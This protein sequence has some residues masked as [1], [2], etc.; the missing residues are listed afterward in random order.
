M[1]DARDLTLSLLFLLSAGRRP[2]DPIGRL[3]AKVTRRLA[4]RGGN[5]Q[6]PFVVYA[7]HYEVGQVS[8]Y[9]VWRKRVLGCHD[10]EEL[11]VLI[12]MLASSMDSTTIHRAA[13]LARNIKKLL[14][15]RNCRIV[16]CHIDAKDGE[17]YFL[18]ADKSS[19]A[20]WVSFR[21]V[22]LELLIQ[23]RYG[24]RQKAIEKSQQRTKANSLNH[25]Y[26]SPSSEVSKLR[27]P[28]FKKFAPPQSTKR[29]EGSTTSTQVETM[30]QKNLIKN[31]KKL[32]ASGRSSHG[33]V[34]PKPKPT[35]SS[36]PAIPPSSLLKP[37]PTSSSTPGKLPSAMSLGS[38]QT[39]K[40]PKQVGSVNSAK[41]K[42]AGTAK[43]EGR[44]TNEGDPIHQYNDILREHHVAYQELLA[45]GSHTGEKLSHIR[46]GSYR[47][48][49]RL[50]SQLGS[51]MDKKR[52][53]NIIISCE[54]SDA[55]VPRRRSGDVESDGKGVVSRSPSKSS[56]SAGFSSIEAKRQQLTTSL[57][58]PYPHD[59]SKQS[60][61]DVKASA[62]KDS[63]QPQAHD[64]NASS[65][66][67]RGSKQLNTSDQSRTA[68]NSLPLSSRQVSTSMRST[69]KQPRQPPTLAPLLKSTDARK[70]SNAPSRS[71]SKSSSKKV[72]STRAK[73][74][75]GSTALCRSEFS[76]SGEAKETDPYGASGLESL[77]PQG[78]HHTGNSSYSTARVEDSVPRRRT[79]HP[80]STSSVPSL[81]SKRRRVDLPN[82]SPDLASPQPLSSFPDTRTQS[83]APLPDL[84]QEPLNVKI[85]NAGQQEPM[86]VE[87]HPPPVG[88]QYPNLRDNAVNLSFM[89]GDRRS[90]DNNQVLA[91]IQPEQAGV[92]EQDI[93][94]KNLVENA[95]RQH[96]TKDASVTDY[97]RY[98]TMGL[99]SS[100][101]SSSLYD[102]NKTNTWDMGLAEP[103]FPSESSNL[104][105]QGLTYP[106]LNPQQQRN[107]TDG[108]LAGLSGTTARSWNEKEQASHFLAHQPATSSSHYTSN[109]ELGHDPRYE[110]D[111]GVQQHGFSDGTRSING[112]IQ[113]TIDTVK[114]RIATLN[115]LVQQKQIGVRSDFGDFSSYQSFPIASAMQQSQYSQPNYQQALTTV[116]PSGNEG[117]RA[118]EQLL[119]PNPYQSIAMQQS[120][121]PSEA[122]LRWSGE[123]LLQAN[124]QSMLGSTAQHNDTRHV[125]QTALRT[126]AQQATAP[127]LLFGQGGSTNPS[128]S[129]FNP[130]LTMYHQD[131]DHYSSHFK[132][133]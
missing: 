94:M 126:N 15:P 2:F 24:Q 49:E 115:A 83:T 20:K 42:H 36:P 74:S 61:V 78:T 54:E 114:Q 29:D 89:S 67:S 50:M 132:S 86:M 81:S 14:L 82:Q 59:G 104:A 123:D 79:E 25:T 90:S 26:L 91:T 108:H 97:T 8:Y 43:S 41:P 5:I 1:L 70:K 66:A 16:S 75:S 77:K 120:V 118:F 39:P 3:P 22:D 87:Q 46:A 18:V 51:S 4:R 35:T 121:N 107:V 100:P 129:G 128:L 105:S 76:S 44:K 6:A 119:H 111:P 69:S 113:S 12:R 106:E 117:V 92:Q 11:L 27:T 52:F 17:E 101:N 99:A 102:Q 133:Y 124:R 21:D 64:V 71:P 125:A 28:L 65:V 30:S 9:H 40:S 45:Q 48:L 47:R 56:K 57:E 32:L 88:L 10:L 53:M 7:P 63:N 68:Q 58:S 109:V 38:K 31:P 62:V 33:L 131:P 112:D 103:H 98:Q 110:M 55:V 60:Q 80:Q 34:S 85:L 95:L 93:Y 19:R 127:G 73:A 96:Q 122:Q 130:N 23:N 13:A 116:A 37:K 72:S 84:E